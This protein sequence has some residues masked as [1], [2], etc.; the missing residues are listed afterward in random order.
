MIEAGINQFETVDGRHNVARE[1][2]W[3]RRVRTG[4]AANPEPPYGIKKRVARSFKN[5]AVGQI[6]ARPSRVFEP[7]AVNRL[8]PP[9]LRTLEIGEDEFLFSRQGQAR[10]RSKNEIRPCW[11][12]VH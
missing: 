12:A 1:M 5:G 9:T 7:G 11:I 2:L 10:I 6:D 8:F 3:R 4:P